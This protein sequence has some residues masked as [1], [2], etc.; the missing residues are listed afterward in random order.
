[1]D[2]DSIL[3]VIMSD[4]KLWQY[5]MR[6]VRS[7]LRTAKTIPSD[8]F[9]EVID[10]SIDQAFDEVN[11][12]DI[13]RSN[14]KFI[15]AHMKAFKASSLSAAPSSSAVTDSTAEDIA[16]IGDDADEDF[17]LPPFSSS[18]PHAASNSSP[19]RLLK[20]LNKNKPPPSS[21]EA[22][23]PSSQRSSLE[24][25]IDHTSPDDNLHGDSNHNL[26][27]QSIGE[28]E[29]STV[30]MMVRGGHGHGSASGS[31]DLEAYPYDSSRD[32]SPD[33]GMGN[34]DNEDVRDWER[35]ILEQLK[36][37][38]NLLNDGDEDEDDANQLRNEDAGTR[39]D[40]SVISSHD[41]E[42]LD[43][44]VAGARNP[45]YTVEE[46]EAASEEDSPSTIDTKKIDMNAIYKPLSPTPSSHVPVFFDPNE[47][48]KSLDALQANKSL[49]HVH[50]V[51]SVVT[52]VFFRD[53]LDPEEKL[54]LFYSHAEEEMFTEAQN[55]EYLRAESLGMSWYDYM[56]RCPEDELE[57]LERQDEEAMQRDRLMYD[58]GGY[59]QESYNSHDEDFYQSSSEGSPSPNGG[60][61]GPH[62]QWSPNG[63]FYATHYPHHHA[64]HPSLHSL[65]PAREE[66]HHVNLESDEEVDKAGK[67]TNNNNK[68]DSRHHFQSPG[69]EASYGYDWEFE[70]D[71][72][73]RDSAAPE[74]EFENLEEYPDSDVSEDGDEDSRN[75]DGELIGEEIEVEDEE[76][77]EVRIV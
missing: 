9:I 7:R 69:S 40:T 70:R 75:E 73:M 64:H 18:E 34:Y 5:V 24:I 47:F 52:D 20:M 54:L 6:V 35:Q 8:M 48:S 56:H 60:S 32:P 50:F 51:D 66:D 67:D 27:A 12:I 74:D 49:H 43:A 65:S 22:P 3:H 44:E 58:D 53:K 62:G 23:V 76:E 19:K 25:E 16:G 45:E 28:S 46:P 26:S 31:E 13:L 63:K 21:P 42:I 14:I 59:L 72:N 15:K 61:G 41:Q 77:D 57:A 68:Y 2:V 29:A 38:G 30:K 10:K 36:K 39:S 33:V 17:V 1:M 37:D 71:D 55:R 11:I 4:E